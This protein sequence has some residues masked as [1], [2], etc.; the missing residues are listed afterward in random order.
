MEMMDEKHAQRDVEVEEGVKGRL[1]WVITGQQSA[2][3]GLEWFPCK[4]RKNI[5]KRIGLGENAD[6][7]CIFS[8]RLGW[9]KSVGI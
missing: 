3:V 8:K 1:S 6:R 4:L 7:P 2:P 5:L 9:T